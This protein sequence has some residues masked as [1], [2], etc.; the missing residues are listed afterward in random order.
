MKKAKGRISEKKSGNLGYKSYW[1]YIPSKISKDSFFPFKDKE[2]VEIELKAGSLIIR[3]SYELNEITEKYG[4]ADATIPKLL[5]KKALTN[6]DL[7]FIYFRDKIFSYQETNKISN[8]IANG[9]LKLIKEL[10]LSNPKIALLFPNC[11]EFIFCWFGMAK[12]GC[13]FVSISYLLKNDLLEFVLKNSDTEILII[14]YEYFPKF[15][16]IYDKLPK[17]KKVIVRDAPKKFNFTNKIIDFQEILLDD[18]ENPNIDVR[19]FHP[20][21]ILYTSGTTGRPKGVLYRNYYTLSGISI[22]SELEGVG[23]N[24]SPHKIYCLLPLFQAFSQ[25]LVIIPA[26]FYNASVIIPESFEATTFWDDIE[27][28]KPHGFCYFGDI[29]TTLVNQQPKDTDRRH[30]IKYAYGFGAFKKIWEAFERRFGIQIFEVWSLVEGIGMTINTTGSKG[31]KIGSVGKPLR[32]F[33]IKIVGLNDKELPPGRNNIGEILSRTK[34]PFELEYY[35]LEETVGAKIVKNRWV[36]TG[37][38]GYKDKEDF[39]YYLGRQTDMIRRGDE[40]FFAKDIELVANS[41][42]L[43]IESSV[44]EVFIDDRSYNGLKIYVV[45]KKGADLN[46]TDFHN[47]LKEN[48]AFFM[49]PRY[50]EFK[51]NLPKNANELISTFILRKEW[52]N[53]NSRKNTYDTKTEVFLN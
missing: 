27:R 14:D 52:D 26:L 13:V 20:L 11:P 51:K 37:D 42:P 5:E 3:K 16:K 12:A 53:K 29:L 47:Y 28:F 2:E 43:I 46:Y 45:I 9:L 30:S 24:Q 32:G 22:G 6:K 36:H 15:E 40:V 17:I 1:I 31:G 18:F 7:P 10:N 38:F 35:N 19:N 50:I 44:F 39:I 23:F 33:E 8:Q 25:F 34:L 21:E 48:L 41:H 4:I 49:V